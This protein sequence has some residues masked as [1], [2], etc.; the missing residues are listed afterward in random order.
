MPRKNNRRRQRSARG[1]IDPVGR[2]RAAVRRR[3][4]R[5]AG[6][7]RT[8]VSFLWVVWRWASWR[9]ARALDWAGPGG[10][11]TWGDK[12]VTQVIASAT[13]TFQPPPVH[14]RRLPAVPSSATYVPPLAILGHSKNRDN[15][16]GV[17]FYVGMTCWHERALLCCMGESCPVQIRVAAG[18]TAKP[19][20]TNHCRLPGG[21]LYF[22]PRLYTT[23][24]AA[25]SDLRLP[26]HRLQRVTSP[27]VLPWPSVV[28]PPCVPRVAAFRTC[29]RQLHS[30]C[31][32]L[33]AAWTPGLLIEWPRHRPPFPHSHRQRQ[34]GGG[35]RTNL[36][37]AVARQVADRNAHHQRPYGGR[38]RSSTHS[39][40]TL[41][42]LLKLKH[43]H[44]LQRI[45]M[46]DATGAGRTT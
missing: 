1:S 36:T 25:A 19:R 13:R 21:P 22:G 27:A 29:T 41:A 12:G 18:E 9:T 39:R 43:A 31:R 15:A 8:C 14:H 5:P 23:V 37:V 44:L 7:Y 40:P 2:P 16:G 35:V 10:R 6:P 46:A 11:S 17:V 20:A 33:L 32:S 3:R 38:R 24:A 26:F 45:I 34:A 42:P 30:T 4:R 28:A